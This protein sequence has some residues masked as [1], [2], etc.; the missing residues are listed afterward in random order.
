MPTRSYRSDSSLQRMVDAHRLFSP[1]RAMVHAH[2]GTSGRRAQAQPIKDASSTLWL[3][4]P[5]R[6]TDPL[7]ARKPSL[8]A[9]SLSLRTLDA[10]PFPPQSQHSRT[11]QLSVRSSTILSK[12]H[13]RP[14]PLPPHPPRESH[15]HHRNYVISSAPSRSPHSLKIPASSRPRPP[16]S[17]CSSGP[18]PT[19]STLQKQ[20]RSIPTVPS[21]PVT[22]D[23]DGRSRRG[24]SGGR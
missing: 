4:V 6:Q 15:N 21:S 13:R 3:G 20:K 18:N 23:E 19:L 14:H 7:A 17:L 8:C 12:R 1:A 22:R 5:H 9:D 10:S 2:S 24:R 16:N 11:L